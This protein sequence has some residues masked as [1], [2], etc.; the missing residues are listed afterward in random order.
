MFSY[1]FNK[2]TSSNHTSSIWIYRI[3]FFLCTWI[4]LGVAKSDLLY[5]LQEANYFLFDH[6]FIEQLLTNK[7]GLIVLCSRFLLQFC[8]YP[9][10]GGAIIAALLT[11]IECIC[12][13]LFKLNG[14]GSIIG[15]IP[16]F[17]LLILQVSI[18]YE[19]YDS[20]D[21]SYAFVI[22]IGWYYALL[23]FFLYNKIKKN[24]FGVIFFT[25]L[26]ALSSIPMGPAA[27]VALLLI[28]SHAFFSK[29]YKNGAVTTTIGTLGVILSA[30]I[31]IHH[32]TPSYFNY[33]ILYPWPTLFFKYIFYMTLGGQLI[34][35]LFLTAYPLYS[36]ILE[37][38]KYI[39]QPAIGVLFMG[40]T[41]LL[42]RYP[43]A[44][45]EELHLQQLT[46]KMQW[47]ELVQTAN[48]VKVSS[49]LIAAYRTIGLVT[50]DQLTQKFFDFD[51]D[52]HQPTF[53][54]YY[55]EVVYN[56]DFMF[57]ASFPQ[58]SYRWSME[59]WTSIKE[60]FYI[61]Q[62]MSLTAFLNEEYNLCERYL[63]ILKKTLFYKDFA[64]NLE[65]YLDNEEAFYHKYPIMKKIKDAQ[66]KSD[67]SGIIPCTSALYLDFKSLSPLNTERRIL[68]RLYRRELEEFET[69][70]SISM[71]SKE[72]HIPECFQEGIV[73]KSIISNDPNIIKRFPIDEQVRNR[74]TSLI[75]YY[76]KH[77]NDSTIKEQIHEKFGYSYT[78]Y[79]IFGYGSK[80]TQNKISD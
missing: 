32:I 56:P 29:E 63:S 31:T 43:T 48:N 13:Y 38:S 7:S 55:E 24:L 64:V 77:V 57:Y 17:I 20:F 80:N 61:L 27:M 37:H 39:Y 46:H 47:K 14:K 72:K 4:Y 71:L 78:Y 49:K 34:A 60:Q 75:N 36:H 2:M 25:I 69:E 22:I 79:F 35:I 73:L 23:L 68:S 59:A 18:T 16:S 50:T 3:I 42:G 10:I 19:L 74:V 54:K 33:A 52:Y 21:T 65:K 6:T 12:H 15:F 40:L 62:L 51:F 1:F 30:Y 26:V 76:K 11:G 8:Y 41:L 66:A 45:Q 58:I 70:L 5:K 67:V 44:F 53:N 28:S 9:I